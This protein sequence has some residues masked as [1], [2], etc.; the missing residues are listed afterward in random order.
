MTVEVNLIAE[1]LLSG[2]RPLATRGRFVL[3]AA[4]AEGRP[5]SVPPFTQNL[6][7]FHSSGEPS[8]L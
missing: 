2:K 3:V 1:E 7:T 5:T 4:D 8:C 6:D